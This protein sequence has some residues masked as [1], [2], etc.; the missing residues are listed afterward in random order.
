MLGH[1]EVHPFLLMLLD[2]FIHLV[3]LKGVQRNRIGGGGEYWQHRKPSF[4]V[5]KLYHGS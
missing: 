1:L 4:T 3:P 5:N 2:A